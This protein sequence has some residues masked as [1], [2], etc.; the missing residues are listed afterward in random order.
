M[1]VKV[2]LLGKNPKDWKGKLPS[3]VQ[4]RGVTWLESV[5]PEQCEDFPVSEFSYHRHMW[6]VQEQSM[7]ARADVCVLC[8]DGSHSF[9]E[10][11]VQ[12]HWDRLKEQS[13]VLIV[14]APNDE[15]SVSEEDLAK[16]PN[17][18]PV[19]GDLDRLYISLRYVLQS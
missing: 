3:M 9:Q 13:S 6:F 17:V 10:E 15:I 16:K 5:P 14:Y 11:A 19:Y 8:Y 1:A 18:L 4:D 2:A 7:A 12:K